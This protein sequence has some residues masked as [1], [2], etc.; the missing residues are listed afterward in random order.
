MQH[1]N[2]CVESQNKTEVRKK[3][4]DFTL[5]S[6]KGPRTPAMMSRGSITVIENIAYFNSPYTRDVYTF[7]C[8]T[9]QWLL[10]PTCPYKSFTL[11]SIN[12]RI[13]TVGGQEPNPPHFTPTAKLL[14]Y[15][16][17]KWVR[18]YP[19]MNTRRYNTA[20]ASTST[21]VVVIKGVG[22]NRLC[23]RTTEVLDLNTRQWSMLDQFSYGFSLASTT[24]CG[25]T[26]YML[27]F[28]I[29]SGKDFSVHC[30]SLNDL[31]ESAALPE[32]RA[33]KVKASFPSTTT[34]PE[35]WHKLPNLPVELST[36][37]TVNG[38]LIAI[39]GRDVNNKTTNS[40]YKYDRNLNMWIV[41]GCMS[42][43]RS[44][45]L[46]AVLPSND[47]LVVGGF[48]PSGKTNETEIFKVTE[49]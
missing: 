5:T 24:V 10:L 9:F 7:H 19:P 37:V 47:L 16:K 1:L 30:C 48:T 13:T 40:I 3:A 46:A 17:Q 29:Y 32:A 2:L 33:S 26:L 31:V 18:E 35:V 22:D 27:G 11:V 34:D 6:T 39:G 38:E 4:A 8:R 23:L 28:G 12:N 49:I 25:D 14:T 41:L 15:R 44:S 42:T 45:C 36:C 20:A 43:P 21:H